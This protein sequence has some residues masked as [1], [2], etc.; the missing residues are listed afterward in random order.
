[1]DAKRPVFKGLNEFEAVQ[2][3]R[4]NLPHWRQEG[5]T[6]AIAF[7]LADALPRAVVSQWEDEKSV[8][9]AARG[10]A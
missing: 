3:Y 10:I 5:G 1:M 7:R 9:L 6:Y 4:R 8:W 2:V